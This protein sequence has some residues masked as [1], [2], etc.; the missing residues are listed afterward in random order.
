MCGRYK[1]LSALKDC[2][3][4]AANEA[5]CISNRVLLLGSMVLLLASANLPA[6]GSNKHAIV[7]GNSSYIN[8]AL[9]NPVRDADLMADKLE[10]LGFNVTLVKN[11]SL[12]TML[13]AIGTFE[14][15][16]SR[17]KDVAA[18][19]YYAG[20]GVQVS[21]ENYLLPVDFSGET[22]GDVTRTA[23][24]A[25]LLLDAM[26]R[27]GSRVNFL[28]LDACRNNP[29]DHST[30]SVQ[31][32]L[33]QLRAPAG[34]LVAYATAPGQVALDGDGNNSPYTYA[35]VKALDEPGLPAEIVFKRA[36]G[37]VISQTNHQQ[38]PWENSSLHGSDF[39]FRP[40]NTPQTQVQSAGVTG[41]AELRLW[42]EV[43]AGEDI[44]SYEY[45]LKTFPDGAFSELAKMKIAKLGDL[46][47]TD[48]PA[49]QAS[50]QKPN[51]ASRN[52]VSSTS[53][54]HIDTPQ[55]I[56]KARGLQRRLLLLSELENPVSRTLVQHVSN[57]LQRKGFRIQM[58]S[59][60]GHEF[61]SIQ[62]QPSRARQY[63]EA[64]KLDSNAVVIITVH[65]LGSQTLSFYGRN[66]IQSINQINAV[67]L[68]ENNTDHFL[69]LTPME[70]KYTSINLGKQS[71][72]I[73]DQ[74]SK[75]I[76]SLLKSI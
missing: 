75:Q 57:V 25:N 45:Y 76:I 32:G 58:R 18:F 63:I 23:V 59:V 71:A 2:F 26:E 1:A 73:A 47:V 51:V 34:T 50:M 62:Q 69:Y 72:L 49:S 4:R 60:P 15:R 21:G 35:L 24:N 74:T 17:H 40:Q 36:R 14:N 10:E 5:L 52:R 12:S 64:E 44:S 9:D 43:V 11:A 41:D 13:A 56:D 29:F 70:L 20:H 19:A 16:I 30:R 66:T 55:A 7:I 22:A 37:L 61:E 48:L 38:V 42:Q 31:G 46:S 3:V 54:V 33:A 65:E 67:I 53:T 28:V 39:Y 6:Q 27:A 8:N 68:D